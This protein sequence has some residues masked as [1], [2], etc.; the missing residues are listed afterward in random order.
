MDRENIINRHAGMHWVVGPSQWET[1]QLLST[2]PN[3]LTAFFW[4]TKYLSKYRLNF[5]RAATTLRLT[6]RG[7]YEQ[8]GE[9][10]SEMIREIDGLDH[11][12]KSYSN[13]LEPLAKQG[14]NAIVKFDP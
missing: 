3:K 7:A 11:A 13:Y 9:K 6:I 14:L 4:S 2:N 10:A 5:G 12:L 8:E 1:N